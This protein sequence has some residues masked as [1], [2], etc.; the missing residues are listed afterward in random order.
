MIKGI[1][2]VVGFWFMVFAVLFVVAVFPHLVAALALLTLFCMLVVFVIGL[3]Y[4][5]YLSY[6]N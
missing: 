1:L 2:A 4:D 3:S 6:R 5:I